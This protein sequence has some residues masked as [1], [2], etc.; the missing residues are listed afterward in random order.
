M[1][2]LVFKSIKSKLTF[3]LIIPGLL[4]LLIV[5]GITYRQQ[6]RLIKTETFNKLESIRNLKVQQL[7]KLKQ[8][9]RDHD[10]YDEMFIINPRTGVIDIS[11]NADSEGLDLSRNPCF[12]QPMQTLRLFIRDIYYSTFHARNMMTFSVPIFCEKH[13]QEHIT[14]ILVASVNLKNSLYTLLQ[15]KE[16]LGD[17]GETLIVNKDVVALNDLRWHDNAP[18]NLKIQAEPAVNGARGETGI[19]ETTDYRGAKI[20]A[21]YTHI[22]RTRWGFVAK[23]DLSELYA[24]INAMVA[25]L[26]M[27][28]IGALG[29]ILF[30]AFYIARMIVAKPSFQRLKKTF[31]RMFCVSYCRSWKVPTGALDTLMKRAHWF[32]GR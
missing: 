32:I 22:P 5:I 20:L 2:N 3:W 10:A 9:L 8:Y 6:V 15:N 26:S 31:I 23:Q 4:P 13:D 18:L 16:G 17:T 24:P 1:K 11:T 12:T 27:L 28:V 29:A 30:V 19:I 25:N 14:G 7:E 21:A